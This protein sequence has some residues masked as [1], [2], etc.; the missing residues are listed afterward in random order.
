[1]DVTAMFRG[2][3]ISYTA[4]SLFLFVCLKN[5]SFQCSM[6]NFK[7]RCFVRS[8]VHLISGFD[9]SFLIYLLLQNIN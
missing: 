1:M 8:Q 3:Y 5:D 4:Y 7:Q 9:S 2:L 6:R